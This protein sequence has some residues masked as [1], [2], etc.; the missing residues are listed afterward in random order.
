MKIFERTIIGRYKSG[1]PNMAVCMG[2]MGIGKTAFMHSVVQHLRSLGDTCPEKLRQAVGNCVEL[3]VSFGNGTTFDLDKSARGMDDV[4][5]AL[6]A[7]CVRM[8]ARYCIPHD[9]Q[10]ERVQ[11]VLVDVQDRA[12]SILMTGNPLVTMDRILQAISAHHER[13]SGR[14]T[15]AVFLFVDEIQTCL[16]GPEA[17]DRRKF[18]RPILAS[19]ASVI[20]NVRSASIVIA[21][22]LDVSAHP[23]FVLAE[24]ARPFVAI[25]GGTL[26]G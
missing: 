6:R 24:Y 15:T 19:I 23:S 7:L 4:N 25:D 11:S 1:K 13:E 14:S 8:I 26:S 2:A 5:Q 16:D 18:L 9:C 17:A 3:R 12:K 20:W 21:V 10:V 22:M